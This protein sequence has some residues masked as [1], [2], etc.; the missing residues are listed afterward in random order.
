MSK[1]MLVDATHPEETRVAVVDNG[2]LIEFDYE[3]EL[4]KP[5][6]G[7]IYLAK[8]TRVEPSLQAAFVDYGGNRHGFLPFTEIHPDYFRIPVEDREA[9]NE[10]LR[11]QAQ[12][13]MEDDE[14][15]ED[16][17]EDDTDT[18]SDD[19]DEKSASGE[20]SA[21][22]ED[23]DDDN[24]VEELDAS[25][26]EDEKKS[27]RSKSSKSSRSRSKKNDDEDT[28]DEDTEDED[29]EDD[30]ADEESESDAKSDDENEEAQEVSEDASDDNDQKDQ[31]SS[32]GKKYSRY[33]G[34]NSRYKKKYSR[35]RSKQDELVDDDEGRAPRLNI[36]RKYKIQ[37]VVKRGQIVLVQVSKEERGNKGAA[38]TTYLSLAG[39]Y[40]VLMPNSPH[41]GGVSRKVAN[42]KERRRMRDILKE[43]KVP[44]NMSVIVRT[45]GVSRS[46]AEVKRDYDYL[47]R[48][49]SNI[50][51]L[52]LNSIAPALVNEEGSLIKRSI[53]DIYTKDIEDIVVAGDNGFKEAR[54]FMKMM[55]PSYARYV[56]HYKDDRISLFHSEGV[57]AQISKIGDHIVT[58]KSGGYL[59]INPTEALVSI[60]V[61]SGRATKERHIEETALNTNLEAADEVARQLRLRDLAG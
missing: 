32:R 49:W 34:R 36:R 31:K 38:V 14:D 50:R 8:V 30:A 42:Y 11:Q 12:Q 33:R 53:R 3:N 51:E 59:V 57:E 23:I 1:K 22:I 17:D 35:H 18:S 52:T 16:E 10:E 39:R 9:L 2:K 29:T 20:S 61:N 7:N 6:K 60:D 37:E 19:D 28:E 24:E 21:E 27:S 13:N 40:C 46:K 26:N 4:H 15:D 45:A 5:L 44:D 25:K 54:D 56:K 47:Y 43:M 41:A 48:L 55:V 58:L